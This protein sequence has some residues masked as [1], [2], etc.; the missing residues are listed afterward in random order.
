MVFDASKTMVDHARAK[1]VDATWLPVAGGLH[2]DAWAQ[3]EIITK[4]FDFFDTHTRK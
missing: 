4:I 1:G 3:P 2:T